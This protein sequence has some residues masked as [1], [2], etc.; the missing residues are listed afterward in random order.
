[1]FAPWANKRLRDKLY[2]YYH[3]LIYDYVAVACRYKRMNHQK[4]SINVVG[5]SVTR[6][7]NQIKS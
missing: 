2:Y 6:E 5:S 3:G 4:G 7:T 1:L